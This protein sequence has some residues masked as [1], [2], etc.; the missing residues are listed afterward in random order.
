MIDRLHH[1]DEE[2]SDED[3]DLAGYRLRVE[4]FEH[5]D[6]KAEILLPESSE[7]LIDEAEFG[8]DERLPYWAELWPAARAL[9]RHLLESSDLPARAIELGAGLGLPSLA[10]L[11]RGLEVLATDYYPE[12]LRFAR[13]NAERNR[14]P[15]LEIR[16]LDWRDHSA[17]GSSF[18]LVVA[19]DVLYERRNADALLALLP[20]VVQPGGSF[21][22]ADP[23]RVYLPG[24]LEGMAGAGWQVET[25]GQRLEP[26]P[27]GQAQQVKVRLLRIVNPD[28]SPGSSSR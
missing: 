2:V 28:F 20:S 8:A 13:R 22:L 23:G 17:V 27:A 7:D 3:D 26:S 5:D 19:A 10:L 6:F 24:F 18:P 1:A 11:H 21:L 4:R 15:P 12:A 14:L 25:L 16:H 9:A